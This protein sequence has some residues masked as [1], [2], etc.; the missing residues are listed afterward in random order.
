MR[1]LTLL[2]ALALV[3]PLAARA[4]QDANSHE[5]WEPAIRAFE[6]KDRESPPA[7]GAV[8]FVGSSSIQKW[9]TLA[10]DFPKTRVLNRGFG[11]SEIA[12]STYFAGRIITPYKP[13]LIVLY[14]GD[15]DLASGRTP[16]QV[17]ADFGAFVDR[18]RKD[19]P[20]VKIAFVSI[21]PSPSRAALLEKMREANGKIQ[22]YAASHANVVYVDV[23]TPMLTKDG[24]PR[25]ELFG[26]DMLH[27]NRA[28]Y[29]LWISIIRPIVGG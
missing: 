14:A 2:F 18:V 13:R 8:V 23:F 28:G 16:D 15:N 27:M 19:V 20:D 9:S 26:D 22:A 4:A 1:A 10:A 7:P 25:A 6:Q 29:E 11:G 21:K 24:A 12:D 17:L 3:A 5:T